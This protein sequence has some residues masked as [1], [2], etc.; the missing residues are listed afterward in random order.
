MGQFD[1]FYIFKVIPVLLPYL[2][3][4]AL[5]AVL[6]LLLGLGFGGLL[7][8]AKLGKNKI[9]KGL[10]NGYTSVL[11]CT[12]SI[13]LLFLCYYGIPKIFGQFG[14]NLNDI[15]QIYSVLVAF[16][17]LYSAIMSELIRSTYEA[18]DKGQFDA[19]ATVGLTSWQTLRRIILPQC[20]YIALPNLGN[21]IITLL[22]E[23]SL[24]FTIGLVD[25][26]GKAKLVIS[27]NYGNHALEIYL[28]L[29]IVYWV[30]T[31]LIAKGTKM[32]ENSF[33]MGRRTAGNC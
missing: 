4:T 5:I 33:R 22:K 32:L 17:L 13:I 27:L 25:I 15:D 16:V 1:F 7:A 23:S 11:R 29:S 6:T 3:V 12:P 9:A 31:L 20:F 28:A 2:G 24:A 10:A 8:W 21:S 18:I 19:A 26:M 30:L 14:I